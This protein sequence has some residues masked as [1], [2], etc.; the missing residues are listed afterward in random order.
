MK[1][2]LAF[3][4]YSNQM[5]LLLPKKSLSLCVCINDFCWP[6]RSNIISNNVDLVDL[7]KVTQWMEMLKYLLHV[8]VWYVVSKENISL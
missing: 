3:N 8:L 1:R 5:M 2:I 7:K 6:S 4:V